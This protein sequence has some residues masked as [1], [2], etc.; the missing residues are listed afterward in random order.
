MASDLPHV[1]VVHGD[2]A[3]LACDAILIPTDARLSVREHWHTIVPEHRE[4]VAHPELEA[5]RRGDALAH[6][7]APA[8]REGDEHAPLRILTAVPLSGYSSVDEVRPRIRA[9]IEVAAHA[10]ASHRES[11]IGSGQRRALPLV[12]MPLFSSDGGGGAWRRTALIDTVLDEAR[13]AASAFGVDVALVLRKEPD[14]AL[15]QQR[16][17]AAAADSWASVEE[18]LVERAQRLAQHALADRMVP[19][20]GA[21]VSMS[22]GAPSW[23]A[24]L[25]DLAEKIELDADT[26]RALFAGK[27]GELDQASYLARR[28]EQA[29]LDFRQEVAHL[30]ERSR[31]GLAPALLAATADEQAITLNYDTLFERASAAAER[32]RR[33]LTGGS[34]TDLGVAGAGPSDRWL[35]KLHGSADQP[36]SI[37]LT[38]E[39]YLSFA[40]DRSALS[41]IVKANLLTRHLLF[42]GFGLAD[43]HFHEILHDVKRAVGSTE[44]SATAL[45]LF[46]DPLSDGLWGG[47]LTIVPMLTERFSPDALPRAARTLELFLDVLAAYSI[48]SESYLRLPEYEEGLSAEE[49]RVRELLLALE[50]AAR[51]NYSPSSGG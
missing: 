36:E 15:A 48:D 18:R 5:F 38:R 10:I 3:Q 16:R 14:A 11:V 7:L 32:P 9:F 22:A 24:L 45:T 43:D 26:H 49:L 33:V 6:A 51:R 20:M 31:Y 12:A 8:H 28:F 35:L 46:D 42:V 23:A 21:G 25:T 29:D 44:T 2:L 34:R 41:A 40:S 17:R 4:L 19:F 39:D 47:S 27:F 50:R 37:V 1:F 30:V 13:S